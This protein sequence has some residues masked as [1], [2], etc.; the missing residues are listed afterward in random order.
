M[1]TIARPKPRLIVPDLARGL[2]LLGI[3]AAN[4]TQAWIMNR[5]SEPGQPGWTLG[6]V[7]PG[8]TADEV[9][10]VFAALFVHVRGLPMFSTL[11]GFG[12][13]LIVASLHRKG[14]PVARARAVLVRRYLVLAAF[15]L[16]HTFLLFYGDIMTM[17][18]VIGALVALMI[19]QKSKALRI[20]AYS[21]LLF[22]VLL[23]SLGAV[24]IYYMGVEEAGLGLQIAPPTAELTDPLTYLR[25]NAAA[26]SMALSGLPLGVVSLGGL[27]LLGFVW[28]REGYLVDVD[29]HRRVLVTWVCVAAAVVLLIGL[30]LGLAAIGVIDPALEAPLYV[31]NTG[32]GAFTG[33]G[34]LAGLA[35]LTNP[36]QKRMYRRYEETGVAAPPAWTY[37]FVALGKRSMTGYL[38]QSFLFVALVMPFT[39]G[40]AEDATITGKTAVGALVWLITLGLA[41]ALEAAGRQGPFEWAHRRLSYG[42]TGRIEPFAPRAGREQLR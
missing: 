35:L 28:A 21:T 9:L 7:R 39:L 8:E 23:T 6:G 25:E 29:R 17:Y 32:L 15:G 31:A 2:A 13:G 37:P 30:P 22:S 18:G 36:I 14:Y 5:A 26:A 10:A 38:A 11:L 20:I 27:V 16:A 42:P 12:I 33:P 40:L 3:A 24:G 41:A 1:E 34:I 19:T 4:V